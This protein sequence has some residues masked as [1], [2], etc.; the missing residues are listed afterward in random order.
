V[1]S[2]CPE[3][4]RFAVRD[5]ACGVAHRLAQHRSEHLGKRCRLSELQALVFVTLVVD[6]SPA[7][8]EQRCRIDWPLR[9]ALAHSTEQKHGIASLAAAFDS[10]VWCA[11]VD[12]FVS[13][14]IGLYLPK[15]R[16]CRRLF[17]LLQRSGWPCTSVA[18]QS[19][20]RTALASVGVRVWR[21]RECNARHWRCCAACGRMTR[22]AAYSAS[23]AANWRQ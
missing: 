10:S 20:R 1:R 13:N 7:V 16:T 12:K 4:V 6:H 9:V 2:D 11:R 5:L 15:N 3:T 17:F 19:W 23:G 18:S 21:R 14:L 8:I 22:A